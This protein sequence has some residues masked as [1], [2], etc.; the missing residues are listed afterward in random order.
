[1]AASTVPELAILFT[2][3]SIAAAAHVALAVHSSY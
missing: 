3:T 1:M 2:G